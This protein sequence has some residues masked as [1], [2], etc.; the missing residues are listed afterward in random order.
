MKFGN[1]KAKSA[2]TAMRR[3]VS[4][5]S[6]VDAWLKRDRFVFVGWFGYMELREC[7]GLILW[8]YDPDA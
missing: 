5:S 7:D 1:S 2:Q 3:K 8:L 4:L 6:L